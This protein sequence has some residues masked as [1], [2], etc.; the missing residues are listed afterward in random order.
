[1]LGVAVRGLSLF[2]H[3][4]VVVVRKWFLW[5]DVRDINYKDKKFTFRL[6][7]LLWVCFCGCLC[8]GLLLL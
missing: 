5:Q 4:D 6:V 1:M 8:C 3:N 2:D 7:L